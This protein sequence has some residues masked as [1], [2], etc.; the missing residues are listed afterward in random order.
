M[1]WLH[2]RARLARSLEQVKLSKEE[3]QRIKESF[4][5]EKEEWEKIAQQLDKETLGC[6]SIGLCAF[7]KAQ[8][9]RWNKRQYLAEE[10]YNRILNSELS[11]R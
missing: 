8:V 2:L 9:E 10:E 11:S 4:S 5:F 7:A 6:Y 3:A 1:E